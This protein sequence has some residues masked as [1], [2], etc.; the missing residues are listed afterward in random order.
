MLASGGTVPSTRAKTSAES[1]NV[2]AKVFISYRRADS[3]TF[4]GRIYDRLVLHFG[5]ENVFKDVDDIPLG[6]NFVTYIQQ[7]LAECAVE[8]VVIGRSWLDARDQAGSRRLEDPSDYVRLEI[9][10]AERLGLTLIPVLVD[11]VSMPTIADLPP[12]LQSLALLNAIAMRNDPDFSHDMERLIAGMERLLAMQVRPPAAAPPLASTTG[13]QPHGTVQAA[14]EPS[15]TLP[16]NVTTADVMPG[17]MPVSTPLQEPV[18]AATIDGVPFG[19]GSS[20]GQP[21]QTVRATLPP[22]APVSLPAAPA[23]SRQPTA[24]AQRSR[25]MVAI[26]IRYG[27]PLGILGA[28]I[29]VGSSQID[30]VI[31]HY[32]LHF[33][34]VLL[35][36]AI[37][38]FCVLAMS[39]FF[40]A[41][42]SGQMRAGLLAIAVVVV[43]TVFAGTI[44]VM[45]IYA[46]VFHLSFSAHVFLEQ[47]LDYL[48]SGVSYAL[49]NQFPPDTLL[50]VFLYSPTGVIF[51]LIFG[52]PFAALGRRGY[53]RRLHQ[54]GQVEGSS[55]R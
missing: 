4:S 12:T 35:I 32:R 47:F 53:S 7:S 11:G 55:M 23:T 19:R 38:S 14:A 50:V 13:A 42:A 9:E 41:R 22:R 8:L 34:S 46:V 40:P 2:M 15:A 5:R 10:T 33:G 16:A 36:G 24:S 39:G 29:L 51:A 28:L 3:A 48:T 21:A 45:V 17:V 20:P 31:S 27:L 54:Q 49:E 25:G 37:G 26:A 18:A 44:Q 6:A 43:V 30:A 52:L 1:R